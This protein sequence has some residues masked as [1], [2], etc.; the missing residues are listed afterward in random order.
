MFRRT[1]FIALLTLLMAGQALDAQRGAADGQGR[2]GGSRAAGV[3]EARRRDRRTPRC[4]LW[5]WRAS[6]SARAI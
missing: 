1:G 6:R 5:G 4:R 2:E 3:R